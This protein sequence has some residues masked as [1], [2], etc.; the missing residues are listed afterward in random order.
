MSL[1]KTIKTG[2]RIAFLLIA[3]FSMNF[4]INPTDV[5]GFSSVREI[6]YKNINTVLT[7]EDLDLQGD[8]ND[9]TFYIA[10]IGSDSAERISLPLS[11]D[12][13]IYL[14]TNDLTILGPQGI[15]TVK[16][17][18]TEASREVDRDGWTK[19]ESSEDTQVVYVSNSDGDNAAGVPHYASD[20]G[21]NT[22]DDKPQGP[23][24]KR[25]TPIMTDYTDPQ[26]EVSASSEWGWGDDAA[27]KAFNR[28][29]DGRSNGWIGNSLPSWLEY[30]FTSPRVVTA[31]SIRFSISHW[32]E[33]RVDQAPK[34]WTFEGSNDGENWTTLDAVTGETDWDSGE[35]RL[36]NF[37]NTIE[38]N[39]YRIYIT[40]ANGSSRPYISDLEIIGSSEELIPVATPSMAQNQMR[41]GYPDWML[42]KRGDEWS[43]SN[44]YAR[45]GRSLEEPSVIGTYGDSEIRP[46]LKGATARGQSN[47]IIAGLDFRR[48]R[49]GGSNNALIEDCNFHL[50]DGRYYI[51]DYSHNN[52]EVR[53][54]I[55]SQ[56]QDNGL[57]NGL[58]LQNCNSILFEETLHNLHI[59]Q[60]LS[61]DTHQRKRNMFYIQ[62]GNENFR[63]YRNIV[64]N[65]VRH[66]IQARNGG[67]SI[68]YENI[69]SNCP[70]SLAVG[71]GG[72]AH[73]NTDGTYAKIENNI[74]IDGRSWD[75]GL[76]NTRKDMQNIISGNIT[77]NVHY[78]GSNH[79]IRL[80][81]DSEDITIDRVKVYNNIV[82]NI[83]TPLH[84][85]YVTEDI[86]I[87]DNIFRDPDE[88]ISDPVDFVDPI[89]TL[90]MYQEYL[91][92]ESYEGGAGTVNVVDDGSGNYRQVEWE[93]GD[94]FNSDWRKWDDARS[95]VI[96]GSTYWIDEVV[97]NEMLTLSGEG[98]A[99]LPESALSGVE[100]TYN[101]EQLAHRE[102]I[103][104]AKQ[105]SRQNWDWDYSAVKIQDYFR[106]GFA[107][108]S[109]PPGAPEEVAD[110][111][112]ETLGETDGEVLLSW[113]AT[114]NNGNN[115]GGFY[116]V[117]YATYSTNEK[118]SV[119]KWW[120]S[121]PENPDEYKAG[122]RIEE[123]PKN[124]GDTEER[125]VRGL[126]P[127]T[128]FYFGIRAYN[129]ELEK[130]G[131]DKNLSGG[132][133]ASAVSGNANPKPPSRLRF[134][135]I[136]TN[137]RLVWD[138]SPSFVLKKYIVHKSTLSEGS[139]KSTKTVCG[140]E[141]EYDI[142][143]KEESYFA[144]YDKYYFTVTAVNIVESTSTHSNEVKLTPDLTPPVIEDLTPHTRVLGRKEINVSVTDDR[145]VY[146][147]GGGYR[148]LGSGSGEYQELEFLPEP[149]EGSPTYEGSAEID[150]FHISPEG[151]EYYITASDAFNTS[152]TTWVQVKSAKDLPEQ[153][154]I[155]PNNPELIF[156]SEVKEVL[157]TDVRGNEVFSEKRGGSSFIVWNPSR[158]GSISLE[159]G[160][161][162]YRVKTDG[163]Y[164][165]GSVVIAK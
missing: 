20:I 158:D 5:Y 82:Y 67:M 150:D 107:V 14:G 136:G 108:G 109:A 119:S 92:E 60:S 8:S 103:E 35:R 143:L 51:S 57:E 153:G 55:F 40:G 152:K 133:P 86:E 164:K 148:S 43:L 161:Y 160:L 162:I 159:S 141:T 42:L 7:A 105:Q 16:V 27:W 81:D 66:G 3:S 13:N 65:S 28:S 90:G 101:S 165:Y 120:D 113:T 111:K 100:Y 76:A 99:S 114:G 117:R 24:L 49:G 163:E 45:S 10:Q 88:V 37:S 122:S 50:S 36:F 39:Y 4:L 31:Y 79:G 74:V 48:Y 125:I 140:A 53:R 1:I 38:Y 22:P 69:F 147:V 6:T 146:E 115:V 96:D 123:N 102:F 34:D 52:L 135:Y 128:T 70:F 129:S 41:K 9:Y 17:V 104:T 68:A 63:A 151:F 95:I 110:L 29:I 18:V 47:S 149:E 2:I 134:N 87:F 121:I 71:A 144:D 46:K 11:L 118:S 15:V 30:Q 84:T 62:R 91:S 56:K 19:I 80:T 116:E 130:S 83:P 61:E 145:Q 58:Y 21:L 85:S 73:A 72:T 155:T 94:K 78:K 23:F 139:V 106:E 75:I 142:C 59:D 112:A 77:F 98:S 126:Y 127:G 54:S 12:E 89:R 156:G 132:N 93:S 25:I 138:K 44:L 124:A 26:G 97:N 154:F 137:A 32:D 157:I 131:F 33:D 64:T